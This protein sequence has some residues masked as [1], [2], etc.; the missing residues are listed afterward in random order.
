M[1]TWQKMDSS[2]DV[3][4][5]EEGHGENKPCTDGM[6]LKGGQGSAGGVGARQGK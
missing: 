1:E 3:G 2:T 4:E 6:V 5:E